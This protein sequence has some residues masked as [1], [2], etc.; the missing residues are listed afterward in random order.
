LKNKYF[1]SIIFLPLFNNLK[2]ISLNLIFIIILIIFSTSCKQ[3][4]HSKSTIIEGALD[5]SSYNF[6]TM[7]NIQLDGEWD[8]YKE[9][10]FTE[11]DINS[12]ENV[13]S[14]SKILV[15][16]NWIELFENK[17]KS[18]SFGYGTYVVN[19]KG[20]TE[21]NLALGIINISTASE[22]EYQNNIIYSSGKI[23]TTPE[24]HIPYKKPQI[25][26]LENVPV[27]FK[28]IIRVSN[29]TTHDAGLSTVIRIGKRDRLISNAEWIHFKDF[30]TLG[31]L[32]I[33]GLYHIFFYI[34]KR[35]DKT[36]LLFGLFCL[37]NSL[38]ISLGGNNS[39]LYNTDLYNYYIF[40]RLEYLTLPLG[41]YFSLFY[42]T[43]FMENSNYKKYRF[44]NLVSSLILVGLDLILS[45]L[46]MT[47]ILILSHIN[48][49]ITSI[50]GL[51]ILTH[52]AIKKE[53]YSAMLLFS[54]LSLIL[55]V[56]ND[57][58]NRYFIINTIQTV[59][60]GFIFFVFSQSYIIT[61]KYTNQFLESEYNKKISEEM[62]KNLEIKV[63]QRTDELHKQSLK[64]TFQKT[65]IENMNILINSLNDDLRIDQIMEKIK[66]YI[67]FRF[68]INNIILAKIDDKTNTLNTEY[69]NLPDIHDQDLLKKIDNFEINIREVS[70]IDSILKYK[71]VYWLRRIN[72]AKS[73]NQENFILNHFNCNSI[74][75]IPL[76]LNKKPIAILFLFIFNSFKIGKN[77]MHHLTV[78]GEQIGGSLYN[79]WLI[80]ETIKNR[81]ITESALKNLKES[82]N[83]LIQA[84]KMSVLGQLVSSI[85][86]EIN[87]P[88]GA[89]KASAQNIYYS[90]D[91]IIKYVPDLIRALESE[92]FEL[93]KKLLNEIQNNY[94]FSTTKEERLAKKNIYNNLVSKNIANALEVS[95]HLSMLKLN[96]IS[97]EY[98]PLW[99]HPKSSEILKLISDLY[100]LKQKSK[101]IE[102][103]VDKT[104]K[105][106]YAL[107]SYTIR[108]IHGKLI[109]YSITEG[110]KT[111]LIIYENQIKQ[112]VE[113]NFD[114]EENIP[115][116]FCYPDEI[117]QVW[118]NLIYNAVQATNGK[119][120][121]DII[122]KKISFINNNSST[123]T[124]KDGIEVCIMDNG[125]G[126]PPEIQK[127]IFDPFF[128][129]KKSGEGTG[130][131][132]HVC[133]E[134]IIKHGGEIYFESQPGLT[135]FFVHLP[136]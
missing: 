114:F 96:E 27:D 67:I 25:I 81:E 104:S 40:L 36:P 19:I 77:D 59:Q 23:A 76:F 120:K 38:R 50:F 95:E 126:I 63:A 47:N 71:K 9:K 100:G 28:V 112:G 123:A 128:T 49:I 52:S 89:I 4:P 32:M 108:D 88:I 44:Y 55:M 45:P 110:I 7:G 41:T 119:G 136:Y 70:F 5:L 102:A 131:G 115:E 1:N 83:L 61:S 64:V 6:E 69:L 87:T 37:S 34:R 103:S 46:I 132:L 10:F 51:S 94:H 127:N 111:V 98:L 13:N 53:K 116:I 99:S 31:S 12:F 84:E 29:F 125:S 22:I 135:K 42:V 68:N 82:Q 11:K 48:F 14:K 113:L 75:F 39:I 65:E 92:I 121:L 130:L 85:A 17:E 101:I 106:V 26:F 56:F 21:R 74:V 20:N 79:S 66:N 90:T 2:L 57:V 97:D 134:I 62:A 73:L 33:M 117:N 35:N 78:I 54:A 24:F 18:S 122:I 91:K 8:F 30:F 93:I 15:P 3:V 80:E 124:L 43:E 86:H 72:L 105:I 107:K 58:L 129:T 133:K 109:L 118:T 16:G 60:I